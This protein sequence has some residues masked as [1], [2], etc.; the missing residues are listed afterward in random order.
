MSEM[1][2]T[3]LKSCSRR[4]HSGGATMITVIAELLDELASRIPDLHDAACRGRAGE[5]DIED[6]RRDKR[7]VAR[8]GD[9]RDILSGN[10]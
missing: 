4:A 1:S 9:L 10:R 3:V 2:V 6:G 8:E 7:A 5:F